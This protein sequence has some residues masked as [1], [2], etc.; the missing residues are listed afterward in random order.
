MRAH[1]FMRE[2]RDVTGA[3]IPGTLFGVS[4][5]S[6]LCPAV[7]ALTFGLL[8]PHVS[9]AA[10]TRS[11]VV[12]W[13]TEANY[14]GGDG[15][16]S[17]CPGGI[18]PSAIDFY[19]TARGKMAYSFNLDGKRSDNDFDE[20]ETGERGVD[21]QLY[22]V[23]GCT[24]S[25]RGMPS[26]ARPAQP[27]TNWDVLRNLTTAWIITITAENG[28]NRDG[29]ELESIATAGGANPIRGA[30]ALIWVAAVP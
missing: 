18:N 1:L 10:E 29:E 15:A 25:F 4:A 17:E 12:N 5:R 21:N 9:T 20:A 28:F 23:M 13:F 8:A 27:E 2:D 6:A 22:R 30:T 26:P 16:D 11:Y 14:Y 7:V 3:N 24:R 19:R